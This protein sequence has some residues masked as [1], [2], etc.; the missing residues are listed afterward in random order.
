MHNVSVIGLSYGQICDR[1]LI[2]W[3]V[4]VTYLKETL[5]SIFTGDTQ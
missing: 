4:Y 3:S 1:K 2:D 5:F